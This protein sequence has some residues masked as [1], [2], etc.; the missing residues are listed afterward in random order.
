VAGIK[1]T[2]ELAVDF[3]LFHQMRTKVETFQPWCVKTPVEFAF[4]DI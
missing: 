2:P 1:Q 3:V 4:L